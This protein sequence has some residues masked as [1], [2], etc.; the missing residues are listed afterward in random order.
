MRLSAG[1]KGRHQASAGSRYSRDRK[2]HNSKLQDRGTVHR[3]HCNVQA[4]EA[5]GKPP[6]SHITQWLRQSFRFQAPQMA[7]NSLSRA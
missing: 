2:Q 7:D 3:I 4:C 6:P 5:R 1:R